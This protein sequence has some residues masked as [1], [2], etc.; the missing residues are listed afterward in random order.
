MSLAQQDAA[1]VKLLTKAD[2]ME[3]YNRFIK[4]S[5]PQRAKTAVYLYAQSTSGGQELVA[6]LLKK[7]SLETE[8]STQV[9]AA[10]LQSEKRNDTAALKTYLKEQLKLS[11]GQISAVVKAAQSP[12]INAKVNGVTHDGADGV[13]S[14]SPAKAV[15][16][17]DVRAYKAA[18]TAS[19][20]ARPA[21]ELSEYEDI[22]SKL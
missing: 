10:L 6:D 15:I 17:N 19:S 7:L 18:L 21:K 4:P 22:D 3:F 9:R 20:G 1:H 11:E 2:M 8:V 13:A 16:I 12:E 5:S 14:P